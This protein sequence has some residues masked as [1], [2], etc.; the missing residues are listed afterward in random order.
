MRIVST[1]L[2]TLVSYG[3]MAQSNGK[4]IISGKV[5]GFAD[6]TKVSLYNTNNRQLQTIA[7]IKKDSFYYEGEHLSEPDF[8]LLV[9]DEKDPGIPLLMDNSHITISGTKAGLPGLTISGSAVNNDFQL[10]SA[11]M[12]A[13]ETIFQN[14]NFTQENVQKIAAVCEEFVS[15]HPAS[16]VS[17]M[18]VS[19]MFQL[20]QDINR[21][22]K[23]MSQVSK[24]LSETELARYL[25]YQIQTG[26]VM[27]IGSKILPF[28]Q[29]D[30]NG[31][32]VSITDFKGKYVLIDFWASWCGPCRQE[33]PN[34]VANFNKYKDKNF[35]VFGVSLDSNKDAWLNAIKK[36]NLTWTH[37]SDLKGWEN[38]VSKM[39]YISSI[40]QNLLIDPD[41]IIIAKNLRGGALGAMLQGLFDK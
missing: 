28:T 11:S 4:L 35:T 6:G 14:Q 12:K 30:E 32:P 40:P 2:L 1:V 13:F 26:K 36:D 22:E 41:G 25:N 19:Q 27:A 31:K 24:D 8:K 18:A 29:N 21:T 33:N 34:V 38:A 23:A 37:V 17:L 5:T 39:F 20:T 9:F 7:T 16:Y 10:F 3:L 15:Q